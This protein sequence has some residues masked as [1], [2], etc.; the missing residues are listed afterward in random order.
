M[1]LRQVFRGLFQ[2]PTFTLVVLAT[3]AIGIGA[4]AAIFS[5]VQGV[6]LKPLPFPN[7]EDLVVVDH[8]APG[9]NLTSAGIAPFLY[10]TYREDGKTLQNAG[11]WRT[12][13][14]S[15]T[16]LAEPEEVVALAVTQ[17]LLPV[18]GVQPQLGRVFSQADDTPGSEDTVILTAGYWRQR[19]G[20]DRSVIGRRIQLDGTPT[21]VIGVLP[22]SFRFLDRK[23]LLVLPMRFD[24]SKTFLG[25]FSYQAIG[26]LKPGVTITQANADLARLVPMA[27]QRFP[28]FP[29]FSAQMFSEARLTPDLRPLKEDLVGEISKVL[30]ILTG[31]IG[32]VLLIACANV[33]NL[34]LVRAE[35][36]QQE[37]AIRSALGAGWGQIAREILAESLVLGVLGGIIGLGLA[38]GGVQLLIALAPA[39]VPRLDEIAID[40]GVL[41]F[42]LAISIV[43]SL[44]FGLLPVLRFANPRIAMALRAGG[45]TATEGRERHRV[46]NALVVVQVAL[47]LVLLISSG[48]MIRTFYALSKVDPGFVLPEH[49]QTFRISLPESQV[50]EPEQVVH[51]QQAIADKIA[52]IPGVTS[53]GLISTL[54]MDGTGR[55]D[56][57]FAEDR[58]YGE[59][60]IPPLRRFKFIQPGVLKTLGIPIRVGRDLTWTD[61]YEKRM[62]GLVSESLARDLWRTPQAAIGKRVRFSSNDPWREVVGVV[63]DSRDDG[64]SQPAPKIAYFPSLMENFSGD[65]IAVNRS[66][67]FVVR[68]QRAGSSALVNEV[69]Q[70]VWSVNP[71]FPLA[72]V[73]TLREITDKS[74]A[75]TSFTL[76]MLA[77]A[78]AMALLLGVAGIYGVISYSVAQRT[79]EIGIRMALGAR[80]GEVTR[81]FVWR[82]VQVAGIGIVCGLLA[83]A[84]AMR[85]L[86]SLLFGVAAF[87]PGTYAAV[88]AGLI[89]AA[90][91]AS[92]LPALRITL[93]DPVAALK[94]E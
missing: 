32:L 34:M 77:I 18:L 63:G 75:R 2:F 70:A 49:L 51:V 26:R 82:G 29:G 80:H 22:D 42:T 35:G 17:E 85:F 79:R 57:I 40:G 36:R 31:T 54:P 91:L 6:I 66:L 45:R 14:V 84:G 83:A 46:K 37:L 81:M 27:I 76:V 9:V 33:A 11:V 56:P 64:L 7:S 30:W 74:M 50:K 61:L 89:A 62:V 25:N 93:I 71:N 43:A 28:P 13:T 69:S 52:A 21:T 12:D 59:R 5:V 55:M 60:E 24:R 78:G 41:L 23:P 72:A 94:S 92:Y 86:A 16:G 38:Y 68:S 4:N 3:L 10:F 48:L 39:N 87:D 20:A 8:T 1:T 47:A 19:F 53:V 67:A 65:K 44:L 88:S 15:V 58:T 73:R 90:A